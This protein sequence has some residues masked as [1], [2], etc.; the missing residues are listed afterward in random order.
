HVFGVFNNGLLTTHEGNRERAKGGLVEQTLHFGSDEFNVHDR[1]CASV[2]V[3]SF[4]SAT[5]CQLVNRS[6][7]LPA[8][9]S[10]GKKKSI[11]S[12]PPPPPIFSR[13]SRPSL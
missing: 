3:W 2:R 7:S 12:P 6:S 5:G 9:H 13:F 4:Y 11:N 1:T 8:P 10:P